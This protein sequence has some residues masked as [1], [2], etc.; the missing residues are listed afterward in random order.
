MLHNNKCTIVPVSNEALINA[1]L[2]ISSNTI[3]SSIDIANMLCAANIM[4]SI[5]SNT[6]VVQKSNGNFIVENGYSIQLIN[7]K[8]ADIKT[9]VW[10]P[11]KKKYALNCAHI[12][13]EG[14]EGGFCGCIK[15]F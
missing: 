8:R 5:T 1:T 14:I 7:V 15:H 12:R 13:I 9:K 4:A 2:S 3:G 10:R 6:S 11:L